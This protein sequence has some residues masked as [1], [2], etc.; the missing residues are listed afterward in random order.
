MSGKIVILPGDP[1]DNNRDYLPEAIKDS[2]LV[3]NE[4]GNNSQVY[5]ERLKEYKD[6]VIGDQEDTWYEYVPVS[7]DGS[8]KVPLV[9]GMHGGLMTGWGQAIYTSW[10]LVADREGFIV[11]FPSAGLRKFWI[12]DCEEDKLDIAA[13]PRED[14]IYINM[15]PEQPED[16]HDMNVI[17]ALIE[18]MKQK[19][20][21][22]AGR[23][24]MQGMSMGNMM[25]SQIVRYYGHLFAG[26]AGSGG[27]SSPGLLFDRNDEV[28][29]R[30]GPLA[31]WQTRLEHDITPP[32]FEGDTEYVVRRNR[33]YW[34]RINGC[35]SLPELKVIGE[36][37]FAFYKGEQA[38]IVFRD[39]KNRDHGQT[40]DDAQL[41]WDYLFSGS[42]RTEDGR[43][44]HEASISPRKGDDFNIVLM[45]GCDRA[46]VNNRL[47]TMSGPAIK[48]QK[49]KYHGLNGDS[50]VRGEY[51]CVPVSF[52]AEVYGDGAG[53]R[54]GDD[55]QSAELT[56]R[57]GR[58]LQL[59]RGSIGCVVDNTVQAMLCEAVYVDGELY[60]PIQWVSQ[61]LFDHSASTCE[62][63]LY[64]TDHYAELSKNMAHLIRDEIFG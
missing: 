16:N 28:I 50:I 46:Y 15:P 30:G 37:N 13:S 10:T 9:V 51:L 7:Y 3:V 17:L 12:V 22:D 6:K 49:L 18:R 1:D 52:I 23:V 33:E 2:K 24:Y 36:D 29:N 27:P 48:R 11:L 57:D 8:R 26:K 47:V 35:R 56:L 64:I 42:R 4:N 58:T 31:V 34:Q 53:V 19:Y 5:P 60:A 14:G 40:F 43:I 54:S 21:I 61:R 55:G 44:V 39:V 45:A 32:H 63:V 59:A 25:T 62:D 20:E 41:V 38:D